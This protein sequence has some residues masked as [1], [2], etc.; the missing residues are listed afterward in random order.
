M[1]LIQITLI[2]FL[3]TKNVN[4]INIDEL[5]KF[6]QIYH[7][8]NKLIQKYTKQTNNSIFN[9]PVPSVQDFKRDIN[10]HNTLIDLYTDQISLLI[11]NNILS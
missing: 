1:T 6:K 7:N 11:K 5:Q 4:E 10:N 9:L 3:K 8:I 2:I